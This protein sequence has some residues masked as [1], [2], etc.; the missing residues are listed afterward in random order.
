MV[1]LLFLLASTGASDCQPAVFAA[2]RPWLSVTVYLADEN[3]WG[4]FNELYKTVF[5]PPYPARA[6]VG[7][8]LRDILVEVSVVAYL[9]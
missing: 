4:R 3:D 1:S 7:A 5:S 9:P 6:V 8:Q 2:A